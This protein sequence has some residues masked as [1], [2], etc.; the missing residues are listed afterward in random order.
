MER[1]ELDLDGYGYSLCITDTKGSHADLT[2]DYAAIPEEMKRAAACLGKEVLGKV[3]RKEVLTNLP[4]IREQAGD[5]AAL[6][7]IHYVCEN[8]RVRKEV[9]AL[10]ENR[11]GDF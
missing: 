8:E 6:R 4:R 11:F 2:S 3:T 9:A 1:I 7:A 10:R 5:R